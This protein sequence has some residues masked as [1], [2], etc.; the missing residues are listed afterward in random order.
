MPHHIIFW[1]NPGSEG[2]CYCLLVQAACRAEAS[3]SQCLLLKPRDTSPPLSRV[4]WDS[5]PS[6]QHLLQLN[7]PAS[8][9]L[10]LLQRDNQQ[11]Q[12]ISD[13]APSTE[14]LCDFLP[15]PDPLSFSIWS[16]GGVIRRLFFFPVTVRTGHQ[17]LL[18]PTAVTWSFLHTLPGLQS[19]SSVDLKKPEVMSFFAGSR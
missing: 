17:I 2:T 1:G 13:T 5:S 14:A 18:S 4:W 19:S 7:N 9:Y 8:S 16:L 11:N 15:L 12:S 6:A 10:S 3:I